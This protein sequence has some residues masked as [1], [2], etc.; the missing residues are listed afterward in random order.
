MDGI[1]PDEFVRRKMATTRSITPSSAVAL[2]RVV[3]VSIAFDASSLEIISRW[4][5]V[6]HLS[7][8]IPTYSLLIIPTKP[9]QT[10]TR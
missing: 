1:W 6:E 7:G 10:L 8:G 2:P 5:L 9:G 4:A 3:Q